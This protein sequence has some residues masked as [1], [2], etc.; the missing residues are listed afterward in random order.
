MWEAA[1]G[2]SPDQSPWSSELVSE[3]Q[4]WTPASHFLHEDWS[5]NVHLG[6]MSLEEQ[7]L[8]TSKSHFPDLYASKGHHSVHQIPGRIIFKFLSVPSRTEL[9]HS[10]G[11][12]WRFLP[13]K[14]K[15]NYSGPW[16]Q[17]KY[18]TLSIFR[19]CQTSSPRMLYSHLFHQF[20]FLQFPE[21]G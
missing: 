19:T 9:C 10:R 17:L 2:H 12:I 13:S 20:G 21:K 7:E 1:E 6:P 3:L 18:T 5:E 15:I 8:R 4:K 14:G 16:T 11:M